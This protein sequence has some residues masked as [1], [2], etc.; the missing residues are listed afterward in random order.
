[1]KTMTWEEIDKDWS[2]LQKRHRMEIAQAIARYC[3]GHK[4]S[5]VAKHLGFSDNHIRRQLDFAGIDTAT[6]GGGS[7]LVTHPGKSGGKGADHAVDRVVRQFAPK[8]NVEVDND[9]AG[10]QTIVAI[11]GEDAEAFESYVEHYLQEG[12]EPG[13]A[14]R[15]AKAEWAGEAAI[16]AG[17]IK[18]DV[19]KRNEKVNRILFPDHDRDT[20]EI[21]FKMHMARVESAARFLNEAKM[22]RLRSKAVRE[23]VASVDTEWRFQV[24]RIVGNLP[25]LTKD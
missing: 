21:D 17:V 12:H 9:G 6:G 14:I 15:L 11:K 1:M 2:G 25:T 4:T 18:E 24:E 7:Q 10:H 19:N 23:R 16:E 13:A 22:N 3:I 20:F 5:E 8:V